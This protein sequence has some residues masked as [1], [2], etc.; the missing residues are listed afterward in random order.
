MFGCFSL[1]VLEASRG[2]QGDIFKN[3]CHLVPNLGELG[4]RVGTVN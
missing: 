1:T 2:G 3:N 4:T